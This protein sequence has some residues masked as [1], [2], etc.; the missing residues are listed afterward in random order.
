MMNTLRIALSDK[1]NLHSLFSYERHSGRS[2]SICEAGGLP[3]SCTRDPNQ[4]SPRM[5]SLCMTC[6]GLS[7]N[8]QGKMHSHELHVAGLT[9]H[10]PI[11]M[12]KWMEP[13]PSHAA[14]YP[15]QGCDKTTLG[16]LRSHRSRGPVGLTMSWPGRLPSC[17]S[18]RASITLLLPR[19]HC[20]ELCHPIFACFGTRCARH[21]RIFKNRQ[22]RPLQEM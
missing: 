15:T 9:S 6:F 13:P 21:L 3:N 1:D 14:W 5:P 12:V 2:A 7:R 19:G 20:Y 16:A 18:L 17:G 11:D 10:L 8:T 4:S 22:A